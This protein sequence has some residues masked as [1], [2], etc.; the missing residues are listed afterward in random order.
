MAK[1]IGHSSVALLR[2]C[3][4]ALSLH[5]ITVFAV[6]AAFLLLIFPFLLYDVLRMGSAASINYNEGN[7]VFQASRFLA[8]KPLYT[9]LT[10]LPLIPVNYPPL[11]FVII[12][13]LGHFTGSILLTGRVVAILSLLLVG[14]LIFRTVEH[15]TSQRS[16]AL[17]GALLWLALMVRMAGDYVGM[18]DPQ[19]LAHFFSLG[20]FCLYVR[21]I[22]KLSIEKIWALA[23][24][25]CLALF[26]KH[27]L[28]AVP[29]SLAA[30]L[31]SRDRRAFWTFA[32]AG[33][34][35]SSIML[36]GS[37]LYG[38]SSL[39]SN[40][41][42]LDRAVSISR[43]KDTITWIFFDRL[44]CLFFLPY[45]VLLFNSPT[46]WLS[47]HLYFVVSFL[48]GAYAAR[49]IG[50]DINAWFDFFIATAMVFGLFAVRVRDAADAFRPDVLTDPLVPSHWVIPFAVCSI[51]IGMIA[52]EFVVALFLTPDGILARPTVSNIRLLQAV[53]M[54]SG[55]ALL[56]EGRQIA[57]NVNLLRGLL[58]H[59]ILASTLL[60]LSLNLKTDL[61]QVL[62]YDGLRRRDK[63]YW[64]DVELLRGIPGP[65]LFEDPLLGFHAGKEQLFDPFSG[66]QMMVY[67]RV[68]EEILTGRIREK[69][70][71]AIVLDLETQKALRELK[72]V[73]VDPLKPK[74][75]LGERWTDNTLQDIADNYESMELKGPGHYVFYVPRN[76]KMVLPD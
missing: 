37:W 29:I 55:I 44:G 33:I 13:A 7:N 14:C 75:T 35:I 21:W 19:L 56:V 3:G 15:F 5:K 68:T 36:L 4:P 22:D 8:G 67:G 31:F 12:G 38:G 11:S 30:T 65:A 41:L 23:F 72:N 48:V 10:D 25:C 27:L 26:I 57:S 60:P 66:S 74:I 69:Y 6:I 39:F 16:G 1:I 18:Y 45:A 20:A 61:E 70:F 49:G 32:F 52:N 17:L 50:V 51:T 62:R 24:L 53:L 47:V 9:P 64:Q 54:L 71:S 58:I 63:I 43:L 34:C 59:G 40:F 46:K 73:Q 76:R 2:D 42:D 28:I